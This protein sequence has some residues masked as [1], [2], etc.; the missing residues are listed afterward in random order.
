MEYVHMSRGAV[1]LTTPSDLIT[2]VDARLAA[3]RG[4]GGRG[5][6][7]DVLRKGGGHDKPVRPPVLGSRGH[8]KIL[9]GVETRRPGLSV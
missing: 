3:E 1:A 5:N 8:G 6:E 7:A 4:E 2:R 9:V